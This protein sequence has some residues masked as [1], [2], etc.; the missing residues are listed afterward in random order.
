MAVNYFDYYDISKKFHINEEVLK[1]K[2]LI[3][4]K[5]FHPD[6]FVNDDEKYA[7]AMEQTSLNNQAFKVL[8]KFNSRL[9][10]IL[11]SHGLLKE[12]KNEIPQDFLAE[13]MDINEVIMD[14]QF[15]YD[16]IKMDQVKAD[17][18]S[19]SMNLDSQI[20]SLT[21]QFDQLEV[22]SSNEGVVILDQIKNIYLKQ[23]YVLRLQESLDKFAPL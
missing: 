20:K 9:E 14:L 7:D 17:T 13:M 18:H 23:K 15:D 1:S 22:N 11:K 16:Q 12:S 5:Q 3:K 21:L 6:F 19:I 10:H 8:S 2:F 4:S